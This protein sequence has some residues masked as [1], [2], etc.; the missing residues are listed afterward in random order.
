MMKTNDFL[1][2]TFLIFSALSIPIASA[3]YS[4]ATY[5]YRKAI[6]FTPNSVTCNAYSVNDTFGINGAAIWTLLCGDGNYTYSTNQEFTGNMAIASET[7][8]AYWANESIGDGYNPTLI[9]DNGTTAVYRMDNISFPDSTR[10]KNNM[11]RTNIPSNQISKAHGL[12]GN[13][14]YFNDSNA[15]NVTIPTS[16]VNIPIGSISVWLNSTKNWGTNYWVPIG[17]SVGEFEFLVNYATGNI[18]SIYIDG[19]GIFVIDK[20]VFKNGNWTF[21]ALSWNSVTDSHTLFVDGLVYSSSVAIGTPAATVLYLGIYTAAGGTPEWAFRGEM[22]EV[23]FYNRSMSL[24]EMNYMYYNGINN[25]TTLSNTEAFA[26]SVN[27]T[28]PESRK[29]AKYLIDLNVAANKTIQTWIYNL[30]GTGNITFT[31]NITLNLT[32]MGDG[33]Y[34]IIVY[35]NTTDG[36]IGSATTNWTVHTTIPIVWIDYPLDG[37]YHND[38]NFTIYGRAENIL[39]D[40]VWTNN[41]NFGVNLGNSTNWRFTYNNIPEGAYTV[42]VYANDTYGIEGNLT[43]SFVIDRTIPYYTN[44]LTNI[45]NGSAVNPINNYIF[46]STWIDA[47]MAV[48]YLE[49]EGSNYTALNVGNEYYRNVGT[50]TNGYYSYRWYGMDLAGNLNSTQRFTYYVYLPLIITVS[51]PVNS[52]TYPTNFVY[53]NSSANKPVDK[54]WY[55]RNGSAPVYFTPAIFMNLTDGDY[56]LKVYAN[57]SDGYIAVKDIHFSVLVPPPP[58]PPIP[59]IIDTASLPLGTAMG[60]IVSAAVILNLLSAFALVRDEGISAAS[61]RKFLTIMATSVIVVVF[62]ASL[63]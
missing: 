56:N 36:A 59:P 28:S 9:Y 44:L 12:F 47:N 62:V 54:W 42:I 5:P 60:L 26:V 18:V 52:T 15:N 38:V 22:D 46:N 49:F 35:A 39:L 7:A 57:D 40:K 50:L 14:T 24:A 58:I 10:Y 53:L 34:S 3:W 41:T 13:G 23:R 11:I 33:S 29:Y 55:S 16:L 4:G 17:D 31:P 1:F 48:V 20:N 27:I 2:V 32:S 63:L 30:N 6:D 61:A 21:V 8:Q 19:T 45:A 43:V 51:D 25:L 37:T